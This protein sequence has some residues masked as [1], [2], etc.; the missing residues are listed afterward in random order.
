M[1]NATT[2]RFEDLAGRLAVLELSADVMD[3]LE[4]AGSDLLNATIDDLRELKG[5][6]SATAYGVFTIVEQFKARQGVADPDSSTTRIPD[7]PPYLNG[8]P[9]SYDPLNAGQYWT[10]PRDAS[11]MW[12]WDGKRSQL[13]PFGEVHRVVIV[14]HETVQ[15]G[16]ED[17]R[18]PVR[19]ERQSDELRG[20]VAA[21]AQWFHHGYGCWVGQGGR[22]LSDVLPA[23]RRLVR[24]AAEQINQRAPVAV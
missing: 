14:P 12:R 19:P 21:G 11:V 24:M 16:N 6:G 1:V 4:E 23:R 3:E 10:D 7:E 17:V 5:V 2:F 15:V 22:L 8:D 13:H 9:S 20:L 18:I